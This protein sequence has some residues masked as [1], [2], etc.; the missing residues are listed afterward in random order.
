VAL[1]WY[2]STHSRYKSSSLS[3]L[4]FLF[5]LRRGGHA[6]A[7]ISDIRLT[8][9]CHQKKN[10]FRFLFKYRNQRKKK[11]TNDRVNDRSFFF[12]LLLLYEEE[13]GSEN[14][15]KEKKQ[16]KNCGVVW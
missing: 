13:K 3:T 11:N 12:L 1:P 9:Y 14:K 8:R 15:T 5:I 2:P 7:A 4:W 10:K 6:A 16:N